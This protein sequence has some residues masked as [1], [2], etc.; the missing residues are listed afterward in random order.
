MKEFISV[1]IELPKDSQKVWIKFICDNKERLARGIF[2]INK[3][4]G[5][6]PEFYSYGSKITN[7]LAWCPWNGEE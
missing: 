4:D 5:N 7:V 1:K 3:E 2:F 6:K